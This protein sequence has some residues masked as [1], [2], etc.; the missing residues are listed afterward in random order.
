LIRAA[1]L[2]RVGRDL[3]TSVWQ[4]IEALRLRSDAH[5]SLSVAVPL[6]LLLFDCW[7][8]RAA[9]SASTIPA[10]L[11]WG[12]L[13]LALLVAAVAVWWI[14]RVSA[15]VHW[16]QSQNDMCRLFWAIRKREDAP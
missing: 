11:A 7:L 3:D 2:T 6:A 8:V 5:V 9:Y 1:V 14:L 13:A 16:V 4:R 10:H 15:I 12:V